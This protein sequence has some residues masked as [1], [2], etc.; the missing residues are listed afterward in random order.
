[1]STQAPPLYDVAIV[2]G[3]PAGLAVAIR[4]AEAGFRTVVLERAAG[5][6]DKACGEGLMPAGVREL[7]AL[8]ALRLVSEAQPFAGIR[9]LQEETGT[10]V[11]ARFRDGTGL[12]IRRTVLLA[13]LAERATGC[14]ALLRKASVR[15]IAWSSNHCVLTLSPESLNGA[16]N[17]APPEAPEPPEPAI[18]ALLVVA[19]DGL[20][21]RL[22]RAAGLERAAKGPRRFGVRRHFALPPWSD[23]VEVYWTKGVEAYVTP[24]GPKAI[25]VAFLW[26]DDE[27]AGPAR[28]DDHLARFP[29][30]AKRLAHATPLSEARGSGP[31]VQ[32]VRARA[33]ERLALVGDAAGYVD[34]ITGQGLSLGFAAASLLVRALPRSLEGDLAPALR[35]YDA[36][37]RGRWLRYALPARGLLALARRPALRRNALHLCERNPALFQALLTLVG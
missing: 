36:S 19:A 16:A 22:R 28:F 31:L 7:E 6:P 1:M 37:L 12:G 35:R 14:G 20:H 4:A 27:A 25:N 24:I 13:A 21:S 11:E 26:H 8:G 17:G 29:S 5:V 9:Y 23:L 30:L 18:A 3:G 15:E 33:G 10:S 34:A 32:R 2:G